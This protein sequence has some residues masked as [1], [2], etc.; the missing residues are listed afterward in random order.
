MLSSR[1]EKEPG[2]T[3]QEK[4]YAL[5]DCESPWISV[6]SSAIDAGGFGVGNAVKLADLVERPGQ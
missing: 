6:R 2:D 4:N 1:Y 5:A 3:A